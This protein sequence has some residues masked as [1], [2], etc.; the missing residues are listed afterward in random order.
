MSPKYLNL[1]FALFF[2]LLAGCSSESGRVS[3]TH[4][5][6]KDCLHCHNVD[7]KEDSHLAF[8]A[9]LFQEEPNE[10]NYEDPKIFC[11]IP[12]FLQLKKVDGSIIYNSSKTNTTND[13]GFNGEGNVFALLQKQAIPSGSYL[14]SIV[15]KSDD[16]LLDSA[17]THTFNSNYNPDKTDDDSNRYSCNACHRID[18]QAA[19]LST[20]NNCRN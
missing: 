19:P 9:T 18:G 17:T 7:L 13:P 8:G 2:L 16:I 20:P 14:V 10:A 1:F 15:N 11:N 4:F 12:L 5:Q 3:G 6:G